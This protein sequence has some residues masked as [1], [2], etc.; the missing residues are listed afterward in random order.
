[1]RPT[2]RLAA[3]LLA[4]AAG[5]AVR[6]AAASEP[7]GSFLYRGATV[8]DV[9]TGK[10]LH[11][12]AILTSGERIVR[13]A[14]EAAIAA[15]TDA[16]VVDMS[17]TWAIPGLINTHEHLATPPNRPFA[18]A[19][20][21]RDLYGGITAVRDMADDLRQLADLTRASLVGEIP[22]PDIAYAAL[23]AGPSFFEDPRTRE[24]T[25]GL[26][27]GQVTWMR[28]VDEATDLP[29]AIAEAHGSGA[30]A[31]KIYANL[32]G[33][34]V[35]AITTEAHRQGMRVWA[36]A[37]VFPASPRQVIDAGVDAVSHVCMLAYQA[38]PQMPDRYSPRPPVDEA[39]FTGATPPSVGALYQDMRARG[40][41]LDATLWVYDEMAREH[42]AHS[43][44]AAPY[45]S[46]ALAERLTAE[47]WR[48][49]V[50]ISAGTD[51][52][53]DVLDP[54]PAL[55]HE[56]ELLHDGA[57]LSLFATLEAAT[58]NG[59][60]AM[61]DEQ[62]LGALEAGKLA[63]IAFLTRDPLAS[64]EAYKSVTLTVKRGTRFPRSDYRPAPLPP[65]VF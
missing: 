22:G 15:P 27:A 26:V 14:P 49:G 61:G 2:S 11:G 44:G 43:G 60:K 46:A 13:V 12:Y 57:G 39:R 63:D 24:V 51:G 54:W 10:E 45:C 42:A 5:L 35:S 56:L 28:A 16:R 4:L 29:R 34:L 41:V 20:M 40:T 17:G 64:V 37:A 6:P 59:A 7:P 62:D 48:A 47:A 19:M 30:A 23:M 36:H 31:I 52:F 38:S 25:A 58:L 3:V 33:P 50:I 53:A 8:I 65:R 32:P 1:M 9:R 55:Q 18:E 21:K